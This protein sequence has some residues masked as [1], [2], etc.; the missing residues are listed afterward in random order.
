MLFTARRLQD[1]YEEQNV[2]LQIAF[3]GLTKACKTVS[4]DG[5]ENNSKIRLYSHGTTI[6]RGMQ[7]SV[8]NDGEYSEPFPVINRHKQLCAMTPTLL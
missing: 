8:Q 1:N 3:V 5:L 4:Y 7:A 2:D 6:S